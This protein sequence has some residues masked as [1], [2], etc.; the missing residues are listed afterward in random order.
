[1]NL[2]SRLAGGALQRRRTGVAL[3]AVA[4][5]VAGGVALAAPQLLP[6]GLAPASNVPAGRTAGAPGS[7][8]A[9]VATQE[10]QEPRRFIGVDPQGNRVAELPGVVGGAFAAAPSWRSPDGSRL[11]GFTLG[12]PRLQILS[13]LN[14]QVV[15]EIELRDRPAAGSV[16]T[17][18]SAMV[19]VG[20]GGQ[21]TVE[22]IDLTAGSRAIA[23]TIDLPTSSP[24]WVVVG[25]AARRIYVFSEGSRGRVLTALSFEGGVLRV[26]GRT[27]PKPNEPPVLDCASPDPPAFQLNSDGQTLVAFCP[28]STSVWWID[29]NRLEATSTLPGRPGRAFLLT[30]LYAPDGQ[31]LYLYDAGSSTI[32]VVDLDRRAIAREVSLPHAPPSPVVA[33]FPLI[34]VAEAKAYPGTAVISP[35]GQWLYVRNG[36]GVRQVHLPELAVRALWLDGT[37]PQTLWV[38]GDG[39]TLYAIDGS[40]RLLHAVN[41][42]TSSR[43]ELKLDRRSYGFLG[44]FD[45]LF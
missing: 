42:Q 22:V 16:S 13:A 30:P 40:G 31:S 1:M 9:W 7:D 8:V 29:L 20:A 41:T 3:L 11:F 21:N 6:R 43:K 23:L 38:S 14:G 44:S 35:D 17:D 18:G 12:N 36:N 19:L 32:Q 15:R 39:R 25:P 2:A 27:A 34:R 45:F 28:S 24:P 4:A 33:L 5:V 26:V 10:G 37:R